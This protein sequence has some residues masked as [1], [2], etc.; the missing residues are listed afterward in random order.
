M[1]LTL[2]LTYSCVKFQ[3]DWSKDLGDRGRVPQIGC[4]RIPI[5]SDR[6]RVTTVLRSVANSAECRNTMQSNKNVRYCVS[7]TDKYRAV[8][9]RY[10]RYCGTK[11][12]REGDS[13]GTV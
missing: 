7:T 11:R 9:P 6:E 1:T 5:D 8:E 4:F 3:V 13:T 2:T 12:Y 10:L